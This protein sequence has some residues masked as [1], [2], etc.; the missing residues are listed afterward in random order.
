MS[1]RNNNKKTEK[2]KRDKAHSPSPKRRAMGGEKV[3]NG[4]SPPDIEKILKELNNSKKDI[5]EFD[6]FVDNSLLVSSHTLRKKI[7]G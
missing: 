2:I 3:S 4:D 7:Q 6:K 1:K 5:K